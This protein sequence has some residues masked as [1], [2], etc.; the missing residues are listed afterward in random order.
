MTKLDELEQRIE[1]ATG[2]AGKKRR[3]IKCMRLYGERPAISR[4]DNRTELCPRCGAMEAME[5][6]LGIERDQW[7]TEREKK[8]YHKRRTDYDRKRP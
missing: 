6:A 4:D 1:R 7:M 2:A 5:D 8:E 3:C